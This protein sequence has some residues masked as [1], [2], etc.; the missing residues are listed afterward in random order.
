MKSL[1]ARHRGV[2]PYDLE[3]TS[4]RRSLSCSE[5]CSIV[6]LDFGTSTEKAL[7]SESVDGHAIVN[8]YE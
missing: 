2:W 1:A 3:G 7:F 6:A 4:S 5:V 8:I